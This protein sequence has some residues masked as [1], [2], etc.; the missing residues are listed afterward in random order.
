MSYSAFSTVNLIGVKHLPLGFYRQ[1]RLTGQIRFL[2]SGPSASIQQMVTT[3]AAQYGV[4]P[5]LALAVAGQESGFN[6][7]K[8]NGSLLVS[9][10]GAIGVMQ[11]EP[12]TAA[13]LGV[14]P[15][16]TQ[17]NINGGVQYL[18]MLLQEFNGNQAQALAAYDWGPGNVSKAIAQYGANWLSVA[19]AETQNYVASIGGAQPAPAPAPSADLT[20]APDMQAADLEAAAAAADSG[21]PGY[22][23]YVA[24]PSTMDWS[25]ILGWGALL[26]GGAFAYELAT[27]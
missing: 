7:T 10:A 23:G 12:A 25:S 4:P 6:Q 21:I 8:P 1:R 19:P 13:Q 20:L 3:A 11:L 17:Q 5:S 14:D 26:L 15:A 9:P 18:A 22:P 2:L 24:S 16:D 27:R